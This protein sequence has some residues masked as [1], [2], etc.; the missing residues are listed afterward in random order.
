MRKTVIEHVLG[1]LSDLGIKHVF[2]VP[3]DYAF[4]VEDAVCES[5]K[6]EWIGNCNELNAAYAADGYARVNGMAALSTTFAVGELRAYPNRV[7]F[8]TM[9]PHAKCSIAS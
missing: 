9:M 1:R 7:L 5:E 8:Q 3:G 2:G 6:M 4:P